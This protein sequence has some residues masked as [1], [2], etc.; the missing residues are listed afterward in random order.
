MTKGKL[1]AN[2]N[3]PPNGPLLCNP[4]GY[5]TI[6][7]PSSQTKLLRIPWVN[8]YEHKWVN[9]NERRGVTSDSY[10]L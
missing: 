4:N 10:I 7:S 6:P 9:I 1:K 3:Q 8:L 5:P 2:P